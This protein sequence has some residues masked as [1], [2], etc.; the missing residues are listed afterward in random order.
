MSASAG[1]TA[2]CVV[3]RSFAGRFCV[4]VCTSSC[5]SDSPGTAKKTSPRCETGRNERFVRSMKSQAPSSSPHLGR[6]PLAPP[7]IHTMCRCS[8]GL[9]HAHA[10]AIASAPSSWPARR[11]SCAR[12]SG[13]VALV[14]S[15]TSYNRPRHSI[16]CYS[17]LYYT[18]LYYTI[19]TILY[20]TIPYHTIL[21]YTMLCYSLQCY[22]INY[23]SRYDTIVLAQ[24]TTKDMATPTPASSAPE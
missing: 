23:F 2:P 6:S 12:A 1:H 3:R 16:L 4:P 15:S 17:I 7:S 11:V 5:M 8:A 22:F 10:L 18:V 19:Y 13:K 14:S 24:P 21:F 20:Y 9:E